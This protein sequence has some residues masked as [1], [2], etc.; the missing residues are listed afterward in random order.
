MIKNKLYWFVI[1]TILFVLVVLWWRGKVK[2]EGEGGPMLLLSL[3]FLGVLT[4]LGQL[5]LLNTAKSWKSDWCQ[6]APALPLSQVL[7]PIDELSI[8]DSLDCHSVIPLGKRTRECGVGE[9][10][11]GRPAPRNSKQ[12]WKWNR[13][14]FVGG[15]LMTVFVLIIR[16]CD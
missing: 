15:D 4:G 7:R 16:I 1:K 5:H 10:L 13:R 2:A 14:L 3:L 9:D 12:L 6:L 11:L 8:A